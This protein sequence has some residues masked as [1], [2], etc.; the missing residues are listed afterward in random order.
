MD[1]RAFIGEARIDEAI[2]DHGLQIFRRLRLHAGGDFFGEKFDQEFRHQTFPPADL[3][4]ASQQ[5][6]AR[7][8]TRRI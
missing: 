7:S 6:L 5:P 2:G 4:Q 8:R 1:L 3:L